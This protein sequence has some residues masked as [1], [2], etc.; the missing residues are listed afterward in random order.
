VGCAP[1]LTRLS[2]GTERAKQLRTRFAS[3]PAFSAAPLRAANAPFL[4]NLSGT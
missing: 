1:S 4:R 2:F 3:D